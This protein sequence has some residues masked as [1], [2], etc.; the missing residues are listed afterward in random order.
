MS[1][2]FLDLLWGIGI[3]I[4]IS[5][6]LGPVALITMK[7]TVQHGLRAGIIS[8]L[9]IALTD[10]AAAVIILLGLHHSIRTFNHIPHWLYILGSLIVF[11]YGLRM[12][13]ADPLKTIERDLPW[14]KHFFASIILALT[15]PSTYLAFGVIGAFLTRFVDRPLFTRAQVAVGFFIGAFI[16][17]SMLAFVAFTQKNRYEKAVFLNKI[18]GGIIMVLAIVAIIHNLASTHAIFSIHL[19]Q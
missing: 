10:T 15:N 14:H 7:R 3:G 12:L 1:F 4:V 19:P 2:S 9:A 6:P 8:G 16:W 13:L 5:L 11:F 18:I 17:W